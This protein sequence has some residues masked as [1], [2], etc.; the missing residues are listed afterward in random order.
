MSRNKLIAANWK[1]QKRIAEAEAFGTKLKSKL[2]ALPSCDMVV[3][4]PFFA[5][6]ALAAVLRD[7]RVALGAQDV[8]W[9]KKGAFTG[10]VSGDMIRDAGGTWVI[11]GH[12]ERRH[13][14]GEGDEVVCNKLKA[15]LEAGLMAVLCVGEQ[16]E[17][18]EAG[19]AESVVREQ[20]DIALRDVTAA[21]L[22]TIV[23]AY[24][25]VWAIGTGKTATPNDAE[26]MHHFIR[27]VVGER[28]GVEAADGLRVLYGGSV[29]PGNAADLLARAEIDGALIGGASLSVDSFVDIARAAG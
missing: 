14:I 17:Q 18:R 1:M 7:T 23:V 24:E 5:L 22:S 4:P 15:A 29:K 21:Q 27:G 9:E 2:P 25:P 8:F 28:F 26:S 10:E 13:V 16:L 11:V 6:P 3:F 12:S 20:L 19:D